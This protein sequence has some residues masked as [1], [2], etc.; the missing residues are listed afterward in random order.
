MRFEYLGLEK[1]FLQFAQIAHHHLVVLPPETYKRSLPE[2][3][4]AVQAQERDGDSTL[5]SDS[6]DLKPNSKPSV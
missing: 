5:S 4:V 6:Q 2:E 3:T 1:N